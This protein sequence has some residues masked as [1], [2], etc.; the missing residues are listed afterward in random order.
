MSQFKMFYK[1]IRI[2]LLFS[3]LLERTVKAADANNAPAS[4][5][6]ETN[7]VKAATFE[8]RHYDVAG[9]TLLRQEIID[10]IFTNATGPEITI[11]QIRKALGQLQLA[12]RERGYVTV[13]IAL[14]QQQLT[15]ATIK[16]DVT[17]ARLADIKVRG[18]RYFSSNNVMRELPGLR[19]NILLNSRIFQRE[20]DEA[21]LNRD[22]QIYPNIVP[23]PLPGTSALMLDVKDRLPLHARID[24]DNYNTPGTPDLRVNAAV[25]YNNLWQLDHQVG[26][27]YGFSPEKTKADDLISDYFFD[28]PQ[29]SYYGAYYRI[30]FG[31][32]SLEDEVNHSTRFGY[33]EATHQ[34]VLPPSGNRPDLTFYASASSSDTGLKLGPMETSAST[35]LETLSTQASGRDFS[36]N[37]DLGAR[38]TYPINVSDRVHLDFSSAVD[39][40]HFALTIFSTNTVT[41]VTDATNS[42]AGTTTILPNASPPEFNSVNYFPITLGTDFS[43]TDSN[44]TTSAS[45]SA[46]YNFTGGEQNFANLAYS[47][48]ARQ[49]FGKLNLTASRDQKM[50]GNCSLLLRGSAQC[51]TGALI[52]NEQFSL[53]GINSV[54]GYFEGDDY[55]D[56]GWFGS[57]EVRL[58]YFQ[59]HVA[60]LD[61]EPVPA[62]LRASV[63]ADYGQRYL[64]NADPGPSHV[65]SMLGAGF[66]VSGNINNH[67]DVRLAIAWPLL[68]SANTQAGDTH[69][70][71]TIGA[72]F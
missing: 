58:P 36:V 51:A 22:R 1:S 40:K 62:W 6:Q 35:A 42:Q 68:D 7:A 4:V 15:N 9:N 48:R 53:G 47:T 21:N 16:L 5:S 49:D 33:N 20:L 34:Y 64:L 57:A 37:E 27:S 63:F 10:S 50:P 60:D 17:E 30:P 44:G 70:Y 32:A 12:Y 14:P 28:E 11:T 52:S 13:A 18:N 39:W 43:E 29:I 38:A 61:R 26:V 59:T 66:G 24:L 3:I 65:R 31:A 2:A 55:G 46:S 72:Q 54:R 67:V 25:Q 56:S 23:G 71:F 45:L 8:V 19:T 69:L 41:V